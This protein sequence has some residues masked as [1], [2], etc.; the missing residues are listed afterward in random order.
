M[1]DHQY[2]LAELA[3]LLEVTCVGD[4]EIVISGLATLASAG[5]GQ[6]SF[7]ANPKYQKAL[8]TTQ[9]EAVIV[10]AD[11]VDIGPANCLVSA[12]P[13]LTYA[14]ASQLFDQSSSTVAGIHPSAVISSSAA[15]DPSASIGPHVS[16]A[17]NVVV[18]AATVIAA[19]C[20]IGKNTV[21]GEACLLHANVSLYHGVS[22]GD[23]VIIHSGAVIGSD[24]FG[25]APS[26]DREKGG[27]VKIAQLGGVVVGDD[28]EIG[29]G[30]TIDRGALDNT[31]IGDRVILDNQVQIA[32]NVELGD[33]TA[34]AGCA[35][36]AGSTQVGKN[37]TIAGGAGIVGHLTIAD[38]VHITAFTLVTKSIAEAGA[39]SSG[40]PMQ[41]SRS[42]RRSAVR[43]SQ[44]DA[45]SKRLS[46]IEKK[47]D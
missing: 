9:A 43:F 12:N 46:D 39:Y 32:H 18:G 5:S 17:D 8:A 28:V 30:C 24:G 22:L 36:I 20:S 15:I 21:L 2:T 4:A 40:T 42:W 11:M 37:C 34:I 33:N 27:W 29:A 35:A 25:F 6:L 31:R 3:E 13:Y 47:L 26:P 41:D 1:A 44:L 10:A 19:G 23:R 16:I 14:K 38:N 45:M 7:L